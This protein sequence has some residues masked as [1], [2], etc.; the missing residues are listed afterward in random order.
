MT[1]KN[2]DDSPILRCYW[3]EGPHRSSPDPAELEGYPTAE[4]VYSKLSYG[5]DRQPSRPPAALKRMDLP[6]PWES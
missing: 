4:P 2:E 1:L 5:R 6:A 3:S